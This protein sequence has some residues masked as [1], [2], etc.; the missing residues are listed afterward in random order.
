M[1][2]KSVHKRQPVA[3]H[4]A[5]SKRVAENGNALVWVVVSPHWGD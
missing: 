4:N 1:P 3:S 2:D 5:Q